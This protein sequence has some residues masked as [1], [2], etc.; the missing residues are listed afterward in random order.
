MELTEYL[1]V[2]RRHWRIWVGCTVLALLLGGVALRL[3]PATYEATARVFVSASPSIPNSAQFVA[4]RSKSYPAVAESAAVLVPVIDHLGL[5]ESSAELRT[6][7]TATNPADTSQVQVTTSGSDPEEVAAISNAVAEQ[8]AQVVEELETPPSGDRPVTLTVNDP[9]T[10]PAKAASPVASFVLAL[11]LVA[12]LFVGLGAAV[13]RSRLDSRLHGEPDVRRAWGEN[14]DV[15]VLAP[16]RGRAGRSA[17]TGRPSTTLARR[18]ELSAEERPIRIAVLCPATHEL[19]AAVAFAEEVAD[20][21]RS[22]EIATTV[23]GPGLA[24]APIADERPHVRLE[25][26][27]PLAPLRFWR[28]AASRYDGVV[29]VVPRGRVDRA[30]LREVRA[31]LRRVGIPVLSIVLTPRT[32]RR[33]RTA[34][35]DAP[36]VATAPAVPSLP[37]G[38]KTVIEQLAPSGRSRS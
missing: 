11:A 19:R 31:I 24:G 12:G 1:A 35:A 26:A 18:L 5:H 15:D 28:D 33:A 30:D 37:G 25:V 7:V 34:P 14:E 13:V 17:L 21:L 6:R 38:L 22:R 9:A 23:T 16:R 36:A 32:R 27:D 20:E 4:Q 3:T 8:L 29:V 10:V 2:F